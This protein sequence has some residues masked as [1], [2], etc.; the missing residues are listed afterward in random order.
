MRRRFLVD[1]FTESAAVVRGDEAHHI[2]RVLRA[3]PGQVFELS[4]GSAVWLAKV[5]RVE[6]DRVEFTDTLRSINE[7]VVN[8]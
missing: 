1:S 5:A 8:G 7:G 3:R 2:A 6:R 4:D